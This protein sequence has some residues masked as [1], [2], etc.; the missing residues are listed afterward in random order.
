MDSTIVGLFSKALL[1]SDYDRWNLE[2]RA[3]KCAAISALR[4]LEQLQVEE[5]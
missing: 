5:E 3:P 1:R 4:A 2:A